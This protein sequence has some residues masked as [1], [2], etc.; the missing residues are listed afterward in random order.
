MC[1]NFNL[2]MKG[3]AN[4]LSKVEGIAAITVSSGKVAS[5]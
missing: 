2:E 3:I 5:A 1:E 4:V